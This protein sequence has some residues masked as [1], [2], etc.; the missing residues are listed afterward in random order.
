MRHLTL[1]IRGEVA[2]M[3]SC[4]LGDGVPGGLDLIAEA[5]QPEILA[6]E[7]TKSTIFRD[8]VGVVAV[9]APWNYPVFEIVALV[10]PA[11]AAGNSVVVKP[12]EV[13][14]VC[15]HDVWFRTRCWGR[16]YVVGI[17]EAFESCGIRVSLGVCGDASFDMGD[18]TAYWEQTACVLWEHTVCPTILCAILCGAQRYCVSYCVPNDPRY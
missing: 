1:N 5:N 16:G 11:L 15:R 12:S 2:E 18:V 3:G 10:L 17:S 6:G 4:F 14:M 8:P 9:I 7:T 13:G